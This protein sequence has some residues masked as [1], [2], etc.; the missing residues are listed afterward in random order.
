[1]TLKEVKSIISGSLLVGG[2]A[3]GAGM[4]ALPV[5]SAT[6]GFFPACVMYFL[7]WLFSMFTGLLMFEALL[8]MPKDSNV[9]SLAKHYLGNG[10][11]IAAWVLYLFLFYCLTIAYITAGGGIF[12]S[13]L[14]NADSKV[15]G[16][17]LFTAVFGS[18]V[19][20][21]AKA[22]DKINILLMVG[23]I[24]SYVIFVALG[25]NKV[26]AAFLKRVEWLGAF[27]ALPIIFTSFSYQGL[28]PSLAHYL[29]YNQKIMR[30]SII[31]GSSI[32]FVAY[33]LWDLLIKGIV[34]VEGAHG[35]VQMQQL[36]ATAV[37]P[38]KYY[39]KTN[40]VYVIGQFFAFFAL[41]TSFFGVTLPLVD[42]W[43]DGLKVKKTGLTRAGLVCLVYLPPLVISLTNPTI[44][45]KALNFAG[46]IGCVFLLGLIPILMVWAGRYRKKDHTVHYQLFGGKTM[47]IALLLFIVFELFFTLRA[48]G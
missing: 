5:A 36:G 20:I 19:F 34:P 44:F 4:L 28:I 27:Q 40:S 8:K 13:L 35:L 48:I 1:M 9:I 23:L 12:S 11:R 37:E 41:T 39:L 32:P 24:A 42:F 29:H 10:G 22:V 25:I 45:F 33:I 3:I 38:L 17:L 2:T 46:G 7:C 18:I 26:N 21:G 47:L 14:S 15:L 31:I 6:G 30:Y 16:T 43:A